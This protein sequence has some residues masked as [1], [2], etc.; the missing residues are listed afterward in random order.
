MRILILGISGLIGHKLFQELSFLYEVFGTL[1]KEKKQYGNKSLFAGYNVIENIDIKDFEF[2][3]GVLRAINPD[4]ILN[5]VG[6]TKRK[7]DNNNPI[8]PL[9]VNAVFPHKLAAWAKDNNK[10]VIHF[11]TDCVFDGK[12]GDY[13]EKSLT[14]A[15]D[16]YGRTKALGE[17]NYDHTLTIRSSFIGQE[18]FD[19]TELLDW[20]LAQSG[21]QIIGF[22]NTLYSG[23]STIYMARVVNT[24]ISHYPNLNG[25]Y[26]LAPEKPISKYE[27]LEIAKK[28]YNMKVEI[29]PDEL[30]V[31]RPT[32]DS[33][34]LRR[35]INLKVPTWN[36]MMTELASNRFFYTN[37]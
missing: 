31:H 18:L 20:F 15:E 32:L 28:A 13:T 5:C 8:E 4:V 33:T 22:R 36:E 29:I 2:L 30:H 27:L 25:L 26:Q 10:R 17:I 34:K 21:K 23:V 7:I 16:L 35:E 19:K 6:I 1:H 24:I 37:F 11:S 3:K 14:T 12:I 9:I